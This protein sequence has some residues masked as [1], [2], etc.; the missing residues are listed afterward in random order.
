MRRCLTVESAENHQ[1]KWLV[2]RGT[3]ISQLL[4]GSGNIIGARE[5]WVS[6]TEAR[7]EWGAM[8]SSKRDRTGTHVY[9]KKLWLPVQEVDK[10]KPVSIPT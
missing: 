2:G 9:S 10:I 1:L 4:L 7:K 5:E 3:C 8:L 6:D